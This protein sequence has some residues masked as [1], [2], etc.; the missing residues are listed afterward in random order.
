MKLK[1]W[2]AVL[3]VAAT[4]FALAGCSQPKA[5]HHSAEKTAQV[6]TKKKKQQSV[7]GYYRNAQD[8]TAVYFKKN[9]RGRYAHG[10]LQACS[11]DSM[12]TWKKIGKKTYE[13]RYDGTG[14][15]TKFR[16]D[17]NN[18]LHIVGDAT[19][20]A[21][22][23]VKTAPFDLEEWLQEEIMKQI[24]A[25]YG[26]GGQSSSS[27][28]DG[29]GKYG[30]EGAFNV[31]SEM[32]GTWYSSDGSIA[33]H[34]NTITTSDGDVKLYRRSPSF[35]NSDE[36][37]DSAVQEATKDWGVA[38][39]FSDNGMQ[40]LNVMGWV[41]SAGDGESYAV[42]TEDLDGKSVKVLVAAS[43]AENWVDTV[44]FPSQDLDDQYGDQQFDDLN[45]R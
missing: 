38:H 36:F 17:K 6:F 12:F 20:K 33:L 23:L 43:G 40:W 39:M 9:H 13:V 15:H 44:Y 31:P 22:I 16:F 10:Y 41:Q 5:S 28:N 32:Q 34:G 30:N 14:S 7:V 24:K 25:K 2:A 21:V 19:N 45:Y 27:S 1:H 29:S 8:L 37:N 42:H 4:G 26:Q 35:V 11:D 18:R 3:L